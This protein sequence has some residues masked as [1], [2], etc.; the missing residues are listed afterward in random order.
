MGRFSSEIALLIT[1]MCDLL[2]MYQNYTLKMVA[3]LVQHMHFLP[4]KE[5]LIVSDEFRV[6]YGTSPSDLH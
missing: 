4:Q 5:V 2:E 6:S 3:G 1:G